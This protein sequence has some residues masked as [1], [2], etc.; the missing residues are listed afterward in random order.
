MG[1]GGDGSEHGIV[2]ERVFVRRRCQAPR[3]RAA[4]YIAAPAADA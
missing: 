3:R 4:L 1:T 2:V